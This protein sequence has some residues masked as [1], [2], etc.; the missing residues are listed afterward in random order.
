MHAPGFPKRARRW[1]WS[2]CQSLHPALH[3]HPLHPPSHTLCPCIPHHTPCAPASPITH[4]VPPHP[5]SH[6]LCPPGA[7]ERDPERPAG[8]CALDPR[9]ARHRRGA[10]QGLGAESHGLGQARDHEVRAGRRCHW[11]WDAKQVRGRKVRAQEVECWAVAMTMRC[12]CRCAPCFWGVSQ[13]QGVRV[14]Q[15]NEGCQGVR[16]HAL[17]VCTS[18]FR[19]QRVLVLDGDR[20][21]Y[22][23][24]ACAGPCSACRHVQD[25]AVLAGMCR[26]LYCLQV[27]A[28]P[29]SAGRHVQDLAVLAGM[30]R[31]LQY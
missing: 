28:G 1:P 5:P 24:Q 8:P 18:G 27:C 6:T 2:N 22:C 16:R 17:Q 12:V 26:T 30:C 3:T 15:S 25:L 13:P 29:C 9:H 31:T 7:A 20:I 14:C 21:L 11:F 10:R 4:P 23:L 19:A